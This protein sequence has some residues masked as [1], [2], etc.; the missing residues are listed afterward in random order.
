M[1]YT[2]TFT[3]SFKLNRPLEP[4][5]Y[6]YLMEFAGTRRMA[7]S[8][9][10][11]EKFEDKIR[12][13]VG[14]PIGPEGAYFVGASGFRGLGADES[15][16]D[17]N[18]PPADQPGL[19]CQWVPTDDGNG[20]EWD[21]GEKFY[22]YGEWLLY[23]LGHFLRPWGY[24]L[25]GTVRWQGEELDDCGKITVDGNMVSVQKGYTAWRAVDP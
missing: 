14:L 17:F 16:A 5:H 3:G 18:S 12:E 22:S 23:L 20:I 8:E 15:I 10:A 25:S 24:E 7:R 4:K 2:T 11:A 9:R 13:A 6:A 1:G 19:W 21:G